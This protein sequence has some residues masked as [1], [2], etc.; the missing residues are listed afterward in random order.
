MKPINVKLVGK[1]IVV[2]IDGNIVIRSDKEGYIRASIISEIANANGVH[3]MQSCADVYYFNGK[4]TFV[5]NDGF[6]TIKEV[7]DYIR[8]FCYPIIEEAL[9]VHESKDI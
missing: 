3:I 7:S 9:I 8:N 4:S 6:K 2:T 1:Q 5:N